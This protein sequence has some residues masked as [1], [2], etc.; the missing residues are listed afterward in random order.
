MKLVNN[1][2]LCLFFVSIPMLMNGQD[3]LQTKFYGLVGS[4]SIAYFNKKISSFTYENSIAFGE[5]G[6][7]FYYHRW[8]NILSLQ[9]MKGSLDHAF[10]L[11]SFNPSASMNYKRWMVSNHLLYRLSH[12]SARLETRIGVGLNGQLRKDKIDVANSSFEHS[13]LF[14]SMRS[15]LDF[16]LSF[17][18]RNSVLFVT[19]YYG[20]YGITNEAKWN[21]YRG[22]KSDQQFHLLTPLDVYWLTNIGMNWKLGPRCV[23]PIGLRF[24][25]VNPQNEMYESHIMKQLYIG[26]CF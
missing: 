6:V 22:A 11:N 17:R 18:M 7:N 23:L 25:N 13:Q 24:E 16:S 20:L 19:S 8:N 4:S 1:W 3:R 26:F 5:I 15:T 14:A 21:A 12:E 9:Y 2:L 10:K